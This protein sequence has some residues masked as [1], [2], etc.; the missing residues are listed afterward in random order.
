MR[1]LAF[2][3]RFW[4]TIMVVAR[5]FVF[6]GIFIVARRCDKYHARGGYRLALKLV[7][8]VLPW[9]AVVELDVDVPVSLQGSLS[10]L[11][12]LFALPAQRSRKQVLS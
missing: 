7:P 10:R 4:V 11:H 8:V 12:L 6:N 3:L 5:I 2:S 1:F 9:V